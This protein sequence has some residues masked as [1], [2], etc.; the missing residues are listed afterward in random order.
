M[1]DM[2]TTPPLQRRVAGRPDAY[3]GGRVYIHCAVPIPG[4]PWIVIRV[5]HGEILET[6]LLVSGDIRAHDSRSPGSSDDTTASCQGTTVGV[7][8]FK[9][10]VW[11]GCVVASTV[12]VLGSL[13]VRHY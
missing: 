6:L 1:H 10:A 9:G 5:Q 2:S 11:F 4:D 3:T 7:P 12:I 8:C 13:T